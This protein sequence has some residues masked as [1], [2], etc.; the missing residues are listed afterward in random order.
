MSLPND[1][2]KMQHYLAKLVKL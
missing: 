1:R 2:W